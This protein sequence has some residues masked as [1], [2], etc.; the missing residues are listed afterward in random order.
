MGL[1]VAEDGKAPSSDEPQHET[2]V[3]EN[4]IEISNEISKEETKIKAG[5]LG[6]TSIA[7][8]HSELPHVEFRTSRPQIPQILHDDIQE[9]E[10]SDN[11]CVMSCAH[12]AMCDDVRRTIAFE[13]AEQRSGR[14]DLIELLQTL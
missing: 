1:N 6:V 9:C 14:I 12:N 13:V 11:I 8:V 10:S 5:V 4:E 7:S 2:E 3:E